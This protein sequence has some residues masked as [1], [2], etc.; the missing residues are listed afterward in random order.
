MSP[1]GH[2]YTDLEWWP[3]RNVTDNKGE[4]RPSA[5]KDGRLEDK[6]A[7]E[8]DDELASDGAAKERLRES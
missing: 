2:Y 4:V 1:T 8:K 7:H 6:I 5:G 3:R